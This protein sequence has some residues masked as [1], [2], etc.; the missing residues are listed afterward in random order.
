MKVSPSPAGPHRDDLA[1]FVA[2]LVVGILLISIADFDP[3]VIKALADLAAA[4]LAWRIARLRRPA[5]NG[6]DLDPA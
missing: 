6:S 2:I 4:Y 1:A 3:L 5:G